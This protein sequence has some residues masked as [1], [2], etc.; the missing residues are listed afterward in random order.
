M[1]FIVKD[2]LAVPSGFATREPSAAITVAD[3]S[4]NISLVYK[5][6]P[7]VSAYATYN[8]SKNYSGAIAVGGGFSG[9]TP[10]A[11]GQGYYL[12]RS[13][14]D[15]LSE[16]YETGLKVS[17]L[18]NT[19][20]LSTAIFDQTRQAKPQGQPSVVE[21]FNGGEFEI[22]Y[23]PGKHFYAT[24]GYSLLVGSLGTPIPFQAY[25]TNQVPNGPPNPNT[26]TLQTTGKLR[27]PGAPEHTINALLTYNFNNGFG[28]SADGVVTS[29]INND[30]QGYL[31]IPWQFTLDASV[32]YRW[33]QWLFKIGGT[34]VTN[35]H[36]WTPAYPTYGL[37]E[38]VP[39]AGAE[40][41]GTVRYT[42]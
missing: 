17:A 3:P 26:S 24:V 14:F 16:L 25:S 30:Y 28:V 18:D 42:F 40:V 5:L 39:D 7:T 19:L 37:E 9:L 35:E 11:N 20:F 36:N 34:N 41:F 31:V 33:K 27:V 29:T 38:I 15:Q 8:N 32:H 4:A 10:N 6:T 21:K 12:P 23:Q 1:H 2:P 22:N 13:N